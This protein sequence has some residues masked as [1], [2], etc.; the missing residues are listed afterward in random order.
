MA[1]PGIFNLELHV[2]KTN[3]NMLSKIGWYSTNPDELL[4]QH[5]LLMKLHRKKTAN[6]YECSANEPAIVGHGLGEAMNWGPSLR[7]LLVNTTSS[8]SQTTDFQTE[9]AGKAPLRQQI[10]VS[11]WLRA[12]SQK[13]R[14]SNFEPHVMSS[15]HSSMCNKIV[16]HDW[17]NKTQTLGIQVHIT[18][19]VKKT[20][21]HNTIHKKQC[22]SDNIMP[23]PWSI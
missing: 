7:R 2:C 9:N 23:A 10:Q 1:K 11:F 12:R 4:K 21:Q 3:Q 19:C 18:A 17:Q 16:L 14:S 13:Q 8:V 6:H 20:S 22:L 5:I 15:I